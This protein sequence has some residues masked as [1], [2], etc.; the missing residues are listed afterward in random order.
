VVGAHDVVHHELLETRELEISEH[1]ADRVRFALERRVQLPGESPSDTATEGTRDADGELDSTLIVERRAVPQGVAV[2]LDE[3]RRV[4]S[5]QVMTFR[6]P[7]PALRSPSRA[8]LRAD[9]E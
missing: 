6:A 2:G 4:S 9:V 5:G 1:E 7:R 8:A 3:L